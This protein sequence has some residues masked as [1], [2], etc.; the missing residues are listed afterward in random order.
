MVQLAV[1]HLEHQVLKHLLMLAHLSHI[2]HIKSLLLGH[3][4]GIF[5][6]LFEAY[7]I[8]ALRDGIARIRNINLVVLV[9]I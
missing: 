4:E 7:L 9:M 2:K 3:D 5:V 8:V 6:N 1:A